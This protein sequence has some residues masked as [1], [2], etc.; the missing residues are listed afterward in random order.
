MMLDFKNIRVLLIGDF[1]IDK[2]IFGDSVRM[3]PEAPVPVLNPKKSYSTL[4]GA[5]NVALNLSVLGA[6]VT[7]VGYVGNDNDGVELVNLLQRQQVNTQHIYTINSQTTV[8]E[9][10]YSNGK[11][12]LRVDKEDIIKNWSPPSISELQSD[13]YDLVIFSD[14][15]KGVLNNSWFSEIES[16]N[17]FVDPKKNDLSFYS[18]AKIITPNLNELQRALGK[19][20]SDNKHLVSCCEKIVT[21]LNLEYII[22]KQGE[23]GITVVGKDGFSKSF[24]AHSVNNVDVTGAGDTVISVFSLVY[25]KTKNVIESVKIANAAASIV[26]GKKGTASVT[27][28]EINSYI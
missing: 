11:Q 24:A 17:I 26:V 14:Y 18:N 9:R 19:E 13:K 20:I 1:M 4:G 16:E 22:A 3:S 28:D 5:G 10:F 8:K 12:V 15:N 6:S 25:T 23:K 21:D 7:C 2:Y 27:I